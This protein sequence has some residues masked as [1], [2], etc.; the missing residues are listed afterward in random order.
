[1]GFY[2]GAVAVRH[3]K[4]RWVVE[5]FAFAPGTYEIGI[6]TGRFTL[7]GIETLCESWH[8]RPNNKTHR[9]LARE[10]AQHFAPTPRRVSKPKPTSAAIEAE[11]LRILGRKSCK[12]RYPWQLA[13]ELRDKLGAT[14]TTLPGSTVERVLAA[15]AKRKRIVRVDRGGSGRYSVEYL[16]AGRT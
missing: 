1:M 6:T 2:F 10:Y 5:P 7:M 15:M 9:A 11:V 8:A 14:K 16:L 3:A 4:A 13:D 12:G